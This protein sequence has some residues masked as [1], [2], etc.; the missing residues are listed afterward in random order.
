MFRS[1]V[2]REDDT[3]WPR[4][5][6]VGKQELEIRLGNEHIS[7]EVRPLP[8]LARYLP[9]DEIRT[10]RP[11]KSVPSPTS[12]IPKIQTASEYSTTSSRISRY[13]PTPPPCTPLTPARTVP[14]LFPDLAAFQDQAQYVPSPRFRNQLTT[15]T[16]RS[17][18]IVLDS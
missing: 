7:F 17:S 5:N 13:A 2:F 9:T 3:Q 18:I 12:K 10:G 16:C 6:I 11:R 14:Y 8:S 1:P 4:K 15:C